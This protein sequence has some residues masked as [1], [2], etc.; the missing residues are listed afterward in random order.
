MYVALPEAARTCPSQ[1]SPG[2]AVVVAASD[3]Q[4]GLRQYWSLTEINEIRDVPL[5]RQDL[6]QNC[7][8]ALVT[9]T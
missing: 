4:L 5:I 3:G 1:A 2:H 7:G 8:V 6:T 9:Y